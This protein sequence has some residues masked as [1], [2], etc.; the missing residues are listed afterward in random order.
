MQWSPYGEVS[1][2]SPIRQ[3]CPQPPS[4]H[5]QYQN[6]YDEASRIR[7]IVRSYTKGLDDPTILCHK[8]HGTAFTQ[9][10]RNGRAGSQMQWCLDWFPTEHLKHYLL[11][12]LPMSSITI[13]GWVTGLKSRWEMKVP[14]LPERRSY[15]LHVVRRHF[16]P[17][18]CS[19]LQPGHCIRQDSW[20]WSTEHNPQ[21]SHFPMETEGV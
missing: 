6:R 10:C 14:H 4:Y 3:T 13:T 2:I 7:E 15:G 20:R 21:K 17:D 18:E 12:L 9:V 5:Y 1:P 16:F 8:T 11:F 19:H